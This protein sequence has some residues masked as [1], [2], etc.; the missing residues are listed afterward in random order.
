MG[1]DS[2]DAEARPLFRPIKSSQRSSQES[3]GVR[4]AGRRSV[5]AVVEAALLNYSSDE[6]ALP[7]ARHAAALQNLRRG[8]AAAGEGD[9]EDIG[10]RVK[11][12]RGPKRKTKEE[13]DKAAKIR[14]A[15]GLDEPSEDEAAAKAEPS[16]EDT[17]RYLENLEAGDDAP[18]SKR[19]KP[20]LLKRKPIAKGGDTKVV[21]NDQVSPDKSDDTHTPEKEARLRHVNKH[22]EGG[23]KHAG[24]GAESDEDADDESM[25]KE[26][27]EA[28]EA[29]LASRIDK[30]HPNVLATAFSLKPCPTSAIRNLSAE[31]FLGKKRPEEGGHLLIDGEGR[32]NLHF[33]VG[34]HKALQKI[35][36]RRKNSGDKTADMLD[37]VHTTYLRWLLVKALQLRVVNKRELRSGVIAQNRVKMAQKSLRWTLARASNLAEHSDNEG[38][39]DEVS[40]DLIFKGKEK[41]TAEST[42]LAKQ[43]RV[44]LRSKISS[45]QTKITI[46]S[47]HGIDL[48]KMA[49]KLTA[50][51]LSFDW[52]DKRGSDDEDD[53]LLAVDI[54]EEELFTSRRDMFK[55]QLHRSASFQQAKGLTRGRTKSNLSLDKLLKS[56][57]PAP[58]SSTAADSQP[59]ETETE[60]RSNASVKSAKGPADAQAGASKD[61]EASDKEPQS[62]LWEVL[63][64]ESSAAP[65]KHVSA[66]EDLQKLFAEPHRTPASS[67]QPGKPET[68]EELAAAAASKVSDAPAAQ[69]GPADLSNDAAL[70]EDSNASAGARSSENLE[71][72]SMDPDGISPTQMWARDIDSLDSTGT[73]HAELAPTAP[74]EAKQSDDQLEISPTAPFVAHVLEQQLEISP[75]APFVPKQQ[76]DEQQLEISPTA[77]FV[78]KV[79]AEQQVEIS[80]T[81]PFVPR[82]ALQGRPDISPT[83]P[84]VPTAVPQ[85][86]PEISPTEPYVPSREQAEISP[87]EPATNGLAEIRTSAPA[88]STSAPVETSRTM[89]LGA[90]STSHEDAA[91]GKKLERQLS[92]PLM[93]DASLSDSESEEAHADGE[94]HVPKQNANQRKREREWLRHKRQAARAEAKEAMAKIKKRKIEADKENLNASV[95]STQEMTRYQD[96]VDIHAVAKPLRGGEAAAL[97]RGG[98]ASEEAEVFG[99]FRGAPGGM[100]KK[101]SFMMK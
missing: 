41:P 8:K 66:Q 22:G 67:S 90:S 61:P 14:K 13:G 49:E 20:T 58:T 62:A 98:D 26:Q 18:R 86:R 91:N 96:V 57:G 42:E 59:P 73:K 48:E 50:P 84:V 70:P 9:G 17:L 68:P 3:Q 65:M 94:Q 76:Q 7:K 72:L 47:S 19:S 35:R 40:P 74:L 10:L 5:D 29:D 78:P 53:N 69:Q 11:R 55:D 87:T 4:R 100:Q 63:E 28:W 99:G 51:S 101:K 6:D 88:V 46:E 24:P 44:E 80:P 54:P 75:T 45:N 92:A 25:S 93:S 83:E 16:F 15:L 30:Q 2:S 33:M 12:T 95:L 37:K 85:G 36:E 79:A 52:E 39:E 56:V 32:I 23:R 64:S 31:S 77:P 1:S 21:S 97:M 82:D 34:T 38:V 60:Q 71:K 43:A 81:A 89:P 27:I